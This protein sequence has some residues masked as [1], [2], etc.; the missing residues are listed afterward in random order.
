[1]DENEIKILKKRVSD[2]TAENMLSPEDRYEE[3]ALRQSDED[4]R[5]NVFYLSKDRKRG[6]P[7]IKSRG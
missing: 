3:D 6:F 5:E 7:R 2:N 4:F 1:M